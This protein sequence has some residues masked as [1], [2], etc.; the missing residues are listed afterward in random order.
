MNKFIIQF[1]I[2]DDYGCK[3]T[4][5]NHANTFEEAKDLKESLAECDY[6]SNIQIICLEEEELES[7]PE[8]KPDRLVEICEMLEL[9]YEN[10]DNFDDKENLE[11][12]EWESFLISANQVDKHNWDLEN[13]KIVSKVLEDIFYV[14]L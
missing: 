1:D 5:E 13:I 4:L 2:E 14:A 12:H 6:Y 11:Q 8:P 7:N 9:I 3:C 10:I